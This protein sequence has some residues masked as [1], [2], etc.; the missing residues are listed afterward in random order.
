MCADGVTSVSSIVDVMMPA[1]I[2]GVCGNPPGGAEGIV[3][4]IVV[5]FV[6]R[7]SGFSSYGSPNGLE[8]VVA[9]PKAK[10]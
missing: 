5:R 8:I 2:G 9:M 7:T 6:N 1:S 3:G 4:G 10:L